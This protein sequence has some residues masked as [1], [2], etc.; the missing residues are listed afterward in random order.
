ASSSSSGAISDPGAE[1]QLTAPAGLGN[2][3]R[4]S[5]LHRNRGSCPMAR[6]KTAVDVEQSLGALQTLGERLESGDLSL[7]ESL[8]AFDHG[9][10]PTRECQQARTQAEQKGAHLLEQDGQLTTEPSDGEVE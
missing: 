1:L 10:A 9:V 6:K 2:V 4:F 5:H 3:Q 8:S 7:E